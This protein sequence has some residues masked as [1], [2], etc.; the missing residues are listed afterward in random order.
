[1]YGTI[2]IPLENSEADGAILGHI[3]PLARL[4][5]AKLWLV[6]VADGHAAR[7]QEQLNLED[8][9]EIREDREYLE[10]RRAELT[11][12]GFEVT[13]HLDRGDPTERI[14]ALAERINAELIAMSTHG[15]GLFKDVLLGS[16][17]SNIRHRTS[18]PVLMVRAGKA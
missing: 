4:V 1:M 10:R 15:H 16:V 13:T 17:A 12:E 18:I 6:H 2:L 11:A 8:S 7:N 3:R 5:G 9:Q 14:L